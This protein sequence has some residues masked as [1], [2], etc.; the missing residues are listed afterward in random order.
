MSVSVKIAATLKPYNPEILKPFEKTLQLKEAEAR[1]AE[2]EARREAI[3]TRNAGES[4]VYQAEK[5]LKE[6]AD[7]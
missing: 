2:D 5:Q 1:A 7:R 6:F 4:M 3:D